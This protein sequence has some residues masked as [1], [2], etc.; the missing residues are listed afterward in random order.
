MSSQSSQVI[1]NIHKPVHITSLA[2][3]AVLV[4][5]PVRVWTATKRDKKSARELT[6]SKGADP[7]SADVTQHLL[8]DNPRLKL[9]KNYRQHIY[10]WKQRRTYPWAGSLG[11]LPVIDLPKFMSEYREH[12][13]EFNKLVDNFFG[14]NNQL[15]DADV[16]NMAFKAGQ[17]FNKA[18]YPAAD[19]ARTYFG[20]DIFTQ[21][22]PEGDYRCAIAQDVAEDVYLN[23]SRQFQKYIN[24]MVDA[25][26]GQL[27]EVMESLSK[28][29]TVETT[30]VDGKVKVSKGKIYDSTVEKAIRYCEIFEQFN[31]TNN[32]ALEEARSRLAKLLT[33]M[34]VETL[35][36]S[37][38]LR[39]TVKN[40]VDDI[41]DKFK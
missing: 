5:T 40:E 14:V 16:S 7:A 3:S 39:M 23:T 41:L 17:F 28:C 27:T 4:D 26:V 30:V 29:C 2:T 6:D 24:E 8:S 18:N 25:Q 11:L 34:N 35:R 20:I 22:V 37:D 1:P 13:T 32:P 31:V 12:E 21:N 15:Y 19:I 33:G 38:H 36:E 9:I 10:N